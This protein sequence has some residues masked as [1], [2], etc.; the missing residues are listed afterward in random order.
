MRLRF[1]QR[2]THGFRNVIK[3]FIQSI[4]TLISC[5]TH[6][7]SKHFL[8]FLHTGHWVTGLVKNY[9]LS[10]RLTTNL[11]FF[12]IL[13]QTW[14]RMFKKKCI[15]IPSS[16]AAEA[17]VLCVWCNHVHDSV[18]V[19]SQCLLLLF[20]A[21]FTVAA[22]KPQWS[23]LPCRQTQQTQISLCSVHFCK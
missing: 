1:F 8:H 5:Y 20:S 6:S 13:G 17:C 14:M 22:E 9:L 11:I 2:V 15:C 3:V 16:V 23:M 4:H 10:T 21:F 18:W 12:L 7:Q 19:K